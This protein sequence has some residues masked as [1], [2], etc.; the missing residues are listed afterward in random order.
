MNDSKNVKNKGQDIDFK[1]RVCFYSRFTA[2]L[3]T[4]G[5][6][7][8]SIYNRRD[9]RPSAIRRQEH[10]IARFH[11]FIQFCCLNSTYYLALL[12]LTNTEQHFH[13]FTRL[14]HTLLG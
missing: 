5:R 7:P 1:T 11:F 4:P 2:I 9:Y 14:E 12:V 13:L 3:G 10:I 8:T 6:V